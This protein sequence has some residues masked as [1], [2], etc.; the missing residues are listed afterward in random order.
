MARV[1]VSIG[2]NIEP[3]RYIRTGLADMQRQFGVLTLSSVYE[4]EAI[5]FEGDNFYNLIAGFDTRMTVQTVASIL[6][7][8]E[9][10][11]DRKRTSERFSARTLDLDVL[12]YDDLIF[13]DKEVEVPRDEILKYAFVLLPLAE[14]AS[15]VKHPVTKQQL[16]DLAQAFDKTRQ[17]LWRVEVSVIND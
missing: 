12:L 15:N 14:I 7:I 10:N 17:S 9:K 1:Y 13:K 5:G 11:N 3:L 6:R 4:S 2:S 8:I 16:G